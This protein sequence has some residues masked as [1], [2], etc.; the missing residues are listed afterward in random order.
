MKI[1]NLLLFLVLALFMIGAVACDDDKEPADDQPVDEKT[2]YT[3]IFEVDGARHATAK[4]EAG[5]T[6]KDEIADPV[7]EN[8]L[9]VSW[10]DGETAVDLA[11]YKVT[12]NVTLTAKFEMIDHSD[13]NVNMTK[14]PGTAYYLVI[15]WWECTDV[16]DDGS[17]KYT[18]Y[19]TE[20]LVQ[21][22]YYNLNLYLKACG[23]SNDDLAKVSFRNY[24]S[25]DVAAMVAGVK[26]DADCEILI[27]VGNNVNSSGNLT[28]LG[29]ND[30]KCDV[31]MGTTPTTR[32][33]AVLDGAG[34]VAQ[35]VY[36]WIKHTQEGKDA[37]NKHLNPDT[38]KK[39]VEVI[40]LTVTVHGDTD[41][42]TELH[43]RET[44]ITLPTIT[45]PT[46]KTFAGFAT[47]ENAEEAQLVANVDSELKYGDVEKLAT[48][49]TLDLYPVFVEK[50]ISDKV[51]IVYV[52][53]SASKSTYITDD[54]LTLLEANFKATLEEGESVQFVPIKGVNG[55]GFNK[56]VLAAIEEGTIVDMV[57]GGNTIT[58]TAPVLV[59]ENYDVAAGHFAKDSRKF[60]VL[61]GCNSEDIAAKLTAFLSTPV[62]TE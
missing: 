2:V 28:L 20:P 36:E 61:T 24:S 11:S 10:M 31:T 62:V 45:V 27:G 44:L 1:K 43:D 51:L 30:G 6:I 33:V 13:L 34:E 50:S 58:S 19:L 23:A 48:G 39:Y 57:I 55:E 7:K 40:N 5:Q 21:L 4:V 18:S 41:A 15:G 3:V 46:G 56:A 32:K 9:F 12:K 8:H 38:L 53:M 26:A 52:H 16:K 60:G 47:S 49:A 35:N 17:P 37:F 59:A 14:E 22:F 29:G 54:E 25:K 42:V